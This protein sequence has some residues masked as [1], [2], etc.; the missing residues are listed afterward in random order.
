[1]QSIAGQITT[2][3]PG[4]RPEFRTGNFAAMGSACGRGA[5]KGPGGR[6]GLGPADPQ[7]DEDRACHSVLSGCIAARQATSPALDR[8]QSVRG[9][10]LLTY[11]GRALG[12]VAVRL[13]WSRE[14]M[15]IDLTAPAYHGSAFNLIRT[16]VFRPCPRFGLRFVRV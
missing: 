11:G 5:F 7:G 4:S 10:I 6:M 16:A 12:P 2:P 3:V 8:V 13:A 1:M 14:V 9:A 15:P